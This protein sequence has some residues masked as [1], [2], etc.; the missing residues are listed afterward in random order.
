MNFYNQQG[1]KY[2]YEVLFYLEIS[3]I[4]SSNFLMRKAILYKNNSIFQL[5]IQSVK[6]K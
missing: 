2:F 1:C 4:R 6:K 3:F 5:A